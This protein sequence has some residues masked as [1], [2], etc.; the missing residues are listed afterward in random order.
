MHQNI[1]GLINKANVLTVHLQDLS[2]SN[3]P[4]DVL[5]V[6]EHNMSQG[7]ETQLALSNYTLAS[8][9]S[10]G[11]RN[12]GSCILVKNIHKYKS[13]SDISDSI[14][15]SNIIECSAIELTEHNIII[16]CIYRVPKYD[17]ASFNIFFNKLNDL[18]CKLNCNR[19][20]VIICGDFNIDIMIRT[21]QSI[22]FNTLISSFNL[23]F[24]IS[25]PTRLQSNTCIDNIIHN[26]RGVKSDVIDLA[27]SDHTAQILKCPV[28]P[29][30]ILSHWFILKR[31]FSNSNVQKFINCLKELSF[32][33]VYKSNDPNEA[34]NCFSD[35]FELFYNLCF[36][37]IRLKISALNKPKWVTKGIRKCCKRKRTMLWKC[38][39][40][41][42]KSNKSDL[43][44]YSQRLRKIIL[45]TQK[46]QNDFYIKNS[47]NKSKA[48][49]N[50]I[51]SSKNK[52]LKDNIAEIIVD[53][54][55]ITEPT[56]IAQK[57]NDYFTDICDLDQLNRTHLSDENNLNDNVIN[58]KMTMTYNSSNSMFMK[59][60][61]PD[62][63]R[64]LINSLKNSKSTGYDGINTVIIKNVA[65]IVSSQISHIVNLC[66]EY[67][68]YWIPNVDTVCE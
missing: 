33:D 30:C 58:P 25:T 64:I 34:Y 56:Q 45:S 20:N 51:Q 19:K 11:N 8:H 32:A 44:V 3:K 18:L 59:P 63:I 7:D 50:I 10:R 1:N 37:Y 55:S 27:I 9:F 39:L 65:N 2:S 47:A 53:N 61:T 12:G 26:I 31:D 28:K 6:T 36:P 17:K 15:I 67:G 54:V 46:V 13:L 21:R 14:S 38:R 22:E 42:N 43:K 68:L 60:S 29:T 5:C 4:I 40:E 48:T 57:F 66:I 52:R 35:Q 23:K 62:D 16:I 24:A 49:W 41:P